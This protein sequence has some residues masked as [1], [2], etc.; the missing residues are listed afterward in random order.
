MAEPTLFDT[1]PYTIAAPEPEHLTPGERRR[2]R[3]AAQITAGY[4]PL[5]LGRLLPILLHADSA[6][7]TAT[8]DTAA[9]HPIRCGTCLHRQTV[10]GG[11]RGFPKCLYGAPTYPNGN[12]A[13]SRAPR[14]T[15]GPGSDC[16]A[17]WPGCVDW[18]P[19]ATDGPAVEDEQCPLLAAVLAG[20]ERSHSDT[21]CGWCASIRRR[22]E[23]LP[24]GPP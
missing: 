11:D 19:R 1:A 21:S 13:P 22:R 20:R 10:S 17:W 15:H 6:G 8:R 16:A 12:L 5:S 9:D 2:R 18:A 23:Q 7:R 4:H 14:A 3:Q 24:A